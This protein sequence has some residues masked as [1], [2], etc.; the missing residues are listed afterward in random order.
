MTI[1]LTDAQ[2][3]FI[4]RNLKNDE[5]VDLLAEDVEN[6]VDL[7]CDFIHKYVDSKRLQDRL[8]TA[9]DCTPIQM[10]LYSD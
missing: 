4:W 5:I 6:S 2:I 8:R 10:E 3:A 9:I 7:F 1:K